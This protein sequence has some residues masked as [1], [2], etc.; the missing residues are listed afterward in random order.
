MVFARGSVYNQGFSVSESSVYRLLKR[1]G[2]VKLREVKT[3][4]ACP[5]YTVKT[6]RTNQMWQTDATYILVKNWG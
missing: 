5:E 3:F 6:K 4:P 1:M 2:L